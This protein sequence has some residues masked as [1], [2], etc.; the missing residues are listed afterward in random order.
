MNGQTHSTTTKSIKDYIL[1][2]FK[3]FYPS[4]ENRGKKEPVQN[5]TLDM[6]RF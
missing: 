4:V 1:Q 6:R 5:K 3:L 2:G